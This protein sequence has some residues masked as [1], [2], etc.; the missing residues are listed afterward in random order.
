MTGGN[1]QRPL[2]RIVSPVLIAVILLTGPASSVFVRPAPVAQAGTAWENGKAYTAMLADAAK[3]AAEKV[4]A[5]AEAVEDALSAGE[6]RRRSGSENTARCRDCTRSIFLALAAAE[7]ASEGRNDP[8][9]E[10]VAAYAAAAVARAI[11]GT[12]IGQREG[13]YTVCF[14]LKCDF[15]RQ[16]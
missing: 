8:L 10:T 11:V 3:T 2:L 6:R 13:L 16:S 5:P 9:L 7:A 12:L 4:V 15:R 14:E 1:F